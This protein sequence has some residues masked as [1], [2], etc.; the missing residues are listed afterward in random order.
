MRR[1]PITNA[2][3]VLYDGDHETALRLDDLATAQADGFRG[4]LVER[5]GHCLLL[6]HPDCA[7]CA[8]RAA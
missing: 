4:E 1:L 3:P 6:Y 5:C 2:D 8:G 7:M